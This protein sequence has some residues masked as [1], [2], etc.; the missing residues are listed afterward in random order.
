MSIE[1][2]LAKSP[3]LRSDLAESPTTS[4][5]MQN[6]WSGHWARLG[7]LAIFGSYVSREVDKSQFERGTANAPLLDDLTD[8]HK[9]EA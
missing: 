6:R 2:L 7:F 8:T 4:I 1:P 5:L 9:G 3:T